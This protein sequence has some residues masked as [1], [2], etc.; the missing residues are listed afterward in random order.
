[1]TESIY[2]NNDGTFISQLTFRC[3]LS[4]ISEYFHRLP[5]RVNVNRNLVTNSSFQFV[6][7]FTLRYWSRCYLEM[8][9]K[10]WLLGDVSGHVDSIII[11]YKDRGLVCY[12]GKGLP[13]FCRETLVTESLQAGDKVL[14]K[15]IL[16]VCNVTS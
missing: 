13:W 2:R 12:N 6:P 1:M 4:F 8:L 3:L 15:P 11:R 7:P 16:Y 9:V 5:N 14:L 10:M